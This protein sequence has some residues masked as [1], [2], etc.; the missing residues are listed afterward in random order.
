VFTSS[1]FE[2]ASEAPPARPDFNT[3]I[4]LMLGGFVAVGAGV[5]AVIVKSAASE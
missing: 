5:G 4:Y 1:R 3:S 2:T